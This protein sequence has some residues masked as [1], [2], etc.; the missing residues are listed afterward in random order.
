LPLLLSS[1]DLRS[2]LSHPMH[3]VY[4][5][6]AFRRT[7]LSLKGRKVI[8]VG[9]VVTA[10]YV[11]ATGS[12]PSLAF[13]DKVTKR[14]REVSPPLLD[15]FEDYIEV[16]NKRGEVDIELMNEALSQIAIN[17]NE[18]VS[19]LVYVNGEE[20]LLVLAAPVYFS[21]P[22]SVLIYGQ[23]DMGAVIMEL[24][25]PMREYLLTLLSH[26]SPTA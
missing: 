23:P 18:G 11:R 10:E 9:D 19:T 4:R 13:I 12:P 17:F 2:F 22:L 25:Y 3:P 24:F 26:L 1:Q 21:S 20:D 5:G 16:S 7:V 14:D 15:Y 8:T 6:E